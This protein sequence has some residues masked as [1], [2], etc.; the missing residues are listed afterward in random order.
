MGCIGKIKQIGKKNRKK[1]KKKRKVD[2][3]ISQNKN[4]IE[5][6]IVVGLGSFAM[7]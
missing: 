2:K 7:T 4:K 6:I 5:S 3:L 1:K